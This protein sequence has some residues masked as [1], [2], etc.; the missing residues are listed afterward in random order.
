MYI[1]VGGNG[2]SGVW[3]IG[4]CVCLCVLWIERREGKNSALAVD[5]LSYA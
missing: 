3:L 5:S 4:V 2:C 1:I